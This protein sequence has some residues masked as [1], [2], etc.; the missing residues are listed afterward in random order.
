ME[1]CAIVLHTSPDSARGDVHRQRGAARGAAHRLDGVQRREAAHDA[2]ED[3][4]L[5]VEVRL[6]PEEQE[7][8][9]PV[10]V[11]ARIGHGKHALTIV[12]TW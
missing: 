10:R 6:R 2:T 9:R 8:L 5:A 12:S 3:H 1:H 7:E 4:V 11:L